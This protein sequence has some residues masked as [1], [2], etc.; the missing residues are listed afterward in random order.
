M[1]NDIESAIQEM[2]DRQAI[3]DCLVRYCRGQDRLDPE[4]TRSAYH[5]D[6][7]DD[8]GGYVGPVDGF[9]KWGQSIHRVMHKATTHALSNHQCELDGNTAH[10]ETYYD[11]TSVAKD[12]KIEHR[13][14]R[15][16]DRLEKR[17]GK[18][19]IA[20]RI[21]MIDTDAIADPDAN[22]DAGISSDIFQQPGRGDKK[23]PS[24]MRP[25]TIDPSRFRHH[26]PIDE[27]AEIN[28]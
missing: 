20:V 10:C 5:D 7:I 18:W 15:Y 28:G 22:E 12:G 21:C 4:L 19:G 27:T 9:V 14:G 26:D 6:A 24:Y 13:T 16:V 23:D 1:I 25:L 2:K 17:N 8:H 3:W 11:Y